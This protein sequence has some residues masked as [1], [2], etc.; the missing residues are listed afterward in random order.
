MGEVFEAQDTSIGRRVALKVLSPHHDADAE[1]IRRFHHEA[2]AV[3][4]I[5]HPHVVTLF[6]FGHRSNGTFFIVQ[7]LLTG[8]NLR[9]LLDKRKRLQVGD[10]LEILVPI[11]TALVAT[12]N[13]GIIH[14]DIKPENIFL[15]SSGDGQIVPKLIDFGIAKMN[16]GGIPLTK[17]GVVMGTPLYVSPE[18]LMGE[19][20][21][22]R[23]DVWAIGAVMFEMLAGCSPFEGATTADVMNNI[24]SARIPRIDVVVPG[25]PREIGGI[26]ELALERDL[27]RRHETML[28]FLRTLFSFAERHLPAFVARHAR[29]LASVGLRVG[30][31]PAMAEAPTVE[32]AISTLGP[33]PAGEETLELPAASQLRPI[34]PLS[35]VEAL[36][37]R[38]GAPASA[39]EECAEAAQQAL[40]VNALHEAV[41]H[42]DRAV[43][44]HGA[45]GTTRGKMRLVQAIACRWLGDFGEAERYAD[46]AM[47][48]LDCGT[49]EWFAAVAHLAMVSGYQ[50]KN[51]RVEALARSLLEL[52]PSGWNGHHVATL[53]E[54]TIAL[55]RCGVPDLAQRLFA[56]AQS[57]KKPQIVVEPAV[58][59]AFDLTR[60]ELAAHGGDPTIYLRRVRLALEQFAALG[61]ARNAC[62]QRANIGNAYMQLGAYSEAEK[63]LREVI[64]VGEPMKLIFITPVRANLG[65]TLARLGDY[66]QALEIER[67]ALEHCLERGYR[68][69]E[70]V[71]RIY[72]TEILSL[73]GDLS[74]AESEARKA[75]EVASS[76]PPLEAYARGSLASVLLKQQ[77]VH[78]AHDQAKKAM[79]TVELLD[80]VEEGEALIR[81]T[82]VLALDATDRPR[83]ASERLAGARQRLLERLDRINDSELQ[84]TFREHVPENALTLSYVP[85]LQVNPFAPYR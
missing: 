52:T 21:D 12:H 70:A 19:L 33:L 24:R 61:D 42:A 14:R 17:P 43:V 9:K 13:K 67:A 25:T 39:L 23:V 57:M 18:L 2:K 30:A 72:L 85:R 5:V 40:R 84:R 63:L 34:W 73:R 56:R 77:K 48:Y 51:G 62:L 31:P 69:F 64:R 50:G 74:G 15:V 83:A 47:Q 29:L 8:E 26:L 76:S 41:V 3:A 37:E 75:I 71:S 38:S 45:E 66:E 1:M 36:P 35:R 16:T 32:I 11:M 46:E 58:A 27:D 68:R 60:A 80:G 49:S 65:F 20:A 55:V 10:V 7:E 44:V 54:L 53:C 28:A 59:A 82:Y 22:G 79:D 78:E 6:E 4:S 81:I